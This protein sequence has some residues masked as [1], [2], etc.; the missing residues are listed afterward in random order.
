[1]KVKRYHECP[2]CHRISPYFQTKCDCGYHF[3]DVSIERQFKVCPSCGL[4]VP[5]SQT[6]CD[7]GAAFPPDSKQRRQRK[8]LIEPVYADEASALCVTINSLRA[9]PISLG[10]LSALLDVSLICCARPILCDISLRAGRCAILADLCFS[11]LR[12]CNHSESNAMDRRHS[13]LLLA[14]LSDFL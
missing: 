3:S 10:R 14:R 1:M 6:V 9:S 4:L 2:E 11:R 8:P 7:C 13:I 5:A 12:Y